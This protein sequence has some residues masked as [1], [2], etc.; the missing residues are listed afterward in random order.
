MNQDWYT[1]QPDPFA[2]LDEERA[3]QNAPIVDII[4]ILQTHV[5]QVT[6]P[7]ET[8]GAAMVPDI[9]M[10]G[11]TKGIP[12]DPDTMAP[13][14]SQ[15]HLVGTWGLH[16]DEVWMD[17]TGSGIMVG[18]MDDGFQ[19]THHEISANYRTDL[20]RDIPNADNDPAPVYSSD[21]HGTSVI[22][23]IIA[24]DNGSGGVG[25][26]FDAQAY[27]IRLDFGGGGNG[28][29]DTVDGFQYALTTGLDVMNNS[30]GYTTSFADTTGINFSGEDFIDVLAAIKDLVDDGRGGLGSNVVFAAG[31]ARVAAPGLTGG[32]NVNYHNVQNS[33][34]T[35]TVAAI[36][37]DGTYSSF[38]TPGAAL[39]VAAGGTS[40]YT[41]DR[42]GSNGYNSGSDYTNFSG[43]SAA[44]P[45]VSGAIAVILEANA[46]LGWRDVQEILAYSTQHNDA[47][48]GSWQYNGAGNWNG[49]G[50]HFSHDYGFGAVDLYQAVRLAETWTLQQTSVNQTVL[51]AVSS[52]PSLA[53]PAT[54]TVSTTINIASDIE[55]EH[56]LID[57]NISHAR[58]GDLIVTLISPDGTE[59][60]LIDRPVNGTFTGIYSFTGIDFLTT[61]NAHWGES[62]AGTWTLEIQ[63]AAGGNSGTLNNWSL[64]F[65]G[66]AH[67]SD[68]VYIYTDDYGDFSGADL[69]ARST[70]TDSTGTDTINLA[71]VRTD[72]T[73][74][75][76]GGTASTVAGETLNI[77]SGTV[78]ENAY[79]G[80]GDDAVT[81][82]SAN[83]SIDAGRGNDSITGSAG[84][85][86][87]NG[88]LG[89]DTLTYL[90]SIIN[91]TFSFISASLLHITHA[92]GAAW[93]DI[94]SNVE[95]FIF[96]EGTYT[97]A[98][99]EDYV[100][101]GGPSVIDGTAGADTLTGTTAADQINAD[102]GDDI[103]Y[104]MG[105]GDTIYGEDGSDRLY[106]GDGNDTIYGGDGN[107]YLFGDNG[108]DMLYGGLGVDYLRGG[109][110]T[111]TAVY[112]AV[113]T[114]FQIALSHAQFYTITDLTGTYGTSRIYTDV[115]TVQ[116]NDT[117][118]A[119]AALGL[120]VGGAVWGTVAPVN[121]TAGADTLTGTANAETFNAG[122][123]NDVVYGMAGNDTIYGE[124]NNDILY[125]GDGNDI[126]YGGDGNDNLYGDG[127][128]DTLYGGLGVD[129]MRGGAGTDTV[130]YTVNSSGFLIYRTHSSFLTIEDTGGTYGTSRIYSDVEYLQFSNT[131]LD[132]N[133]LNLTVGGTPWGTPAAITGTGGADTLSGKATGDTMYGGGGNDTLYG[134][135]GDDLLYGDAG[136]DKIYGGEGADTLV[137]GANND[138]LYG[139]N[140]NDVFAF[141]TA[142]DG[143]DKIYDF[144]AGDRLNITDIL[145]GFDTLTD[146]ISLF[147]SVQ[148]YTYGSTFSI[149]SD[150]GGDNFAEAF[151]VIGQ[152]FNGDSVQTILNA[153]ELIVDQTVL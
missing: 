99:L 9:D 56:V 150:G 104:G 97:R 60:V 77:A 145:T 106:G 121:G 152:Y 26:A 94:V 36:D 3:R 127:G 19:Y 65:M 95:S 107:D 103:V 2:L 73:L 93:T 136:S 105:G 117:T 85:D 76:N 11:M 55:I 30:W 45:I 82:N 43:T 62:S 114:N 10:S 79:L 91:F 66:N 4:D 101:N 31:N 54:G 84:S 144:A 81:G 132:L 141:T 8:V 83:N 134:H 116:F 27:G 70:L 80:D 128:N 17:Y 23:T 49:G 41:T 15:W 153:G 149:D 147:V 138:F 124:A 139:G 96:N 46:D 38:S 111:D 6:T 120:T 126:L 143:L 12:T 133:A 146:D 61:S 25:V 47:A 129:Y 142:G 123:G 50:L 131:T 40:V 140:G 75:M 5:T 110:G 130:V 7:A 37:S 58:A 137:G 113:S 151:M 86:T 89:T 90:E 53:I 112:E 52:S 32:D 64:S 63:D 88:G 109:A 39:L 59:S 102:A 71:A 92:V 20:D 69:T 118:L 148:H 57:L 67:S 100:N 119:L 18:V 14:Q 87:I 72:T 78:I 42:T 122:A 115:E 24:D 98:E 29:A 1:D 135:N 34:Y 13:G 108:D 68:D 48:G 28:I 21:N 35:I 16:A 44:A 51:A 74:N 125:G 33:P 22:G